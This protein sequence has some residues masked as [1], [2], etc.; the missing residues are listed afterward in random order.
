MKFTK[1]HEWAKLEGGIVTV[2][3]TDYAAHQLGDVVFVELPAVGSKVTMGATF[4]TIES[5]KT[6]SDMY[7]PVGG[8]V[9]GVNEDLESNPALVNESP[10]DA[11]WI[12]K[13]KVADAKEFDQ[14]LSEDDYKKICE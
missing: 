11:G 12:V 1:E 2:G 8:E 9:V 6:V 5:V 13:I 10:L 3:I 4:G 7:A 14:L